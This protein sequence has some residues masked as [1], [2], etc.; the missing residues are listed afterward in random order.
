MCF[1]F[2]KERTNDTNSNC[3]FIEMGCQ[4][5]VYYTTFQL[6]CHLKQ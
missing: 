6:N 3:T 1:L 2:I 5:A 4:T